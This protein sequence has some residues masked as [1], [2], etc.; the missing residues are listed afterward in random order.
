MKS[1][2][3]FIG[4]HA[5]PFFIRV[6]LKTIRISKKDFKNEDGIYIFWH[7][8]MLVGWYL[9]K[10]SKASS[11]V[12]MSKDG[13]VLT[14]LLGKWEYKV[15]RGSS[16]KGGKESLTELI[17]ALDEGYKAVVTPD[18]PRGPREDIK[19][20]ALKL[21]F[22]TGKPI[23]PVKIK[24]S[25]KIVLNKSWDKFEIP[26]PFSKC[27][28]IFGNN[29]YYPEYKYDGELDNFKKEISKHL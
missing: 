8:K 17:A 20:G 10:D 16:S 24:Y 21:S 14:S 27:E 18:G 12:S 1:I 22:E 15:I 2:K 28:V 7:S 23:I 25:K 9:F 3:Y 11:L 19:N 6:L 13:D 26:Y 4:N 29:F 5:L